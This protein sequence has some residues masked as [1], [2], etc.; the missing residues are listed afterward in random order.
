[1]QYPWHMVATT[2]AITSRSFINIAA[3]IITLDVSDNNVHLIEREAFSGINRTLEVLLL[4]HNHLIQILPHFFSNLRKLRVLDLSY[5][6]L[7]SLD[8]GLVGLKS[9]NWLNL[10]R[11]RI[12]SLPDYFILEDE[13][14]TS[15]IVTGLT[16]ELQ[17]SLQYN[18]LRYIPTCSIERLQFSNPQ[19]TIKIISL[20]NN[21]LYCDCMD[22]VW[23][24]AHLAEDINGTLANPTKCFFT[25]LLDV[26]NIPLRPYTDYTVCIAPYSDSGHGG[27]QEYYGKICVRYS[28]VSSIGPADKAVD[29]RL[30][31]EYV[32]GVLGFFILILV[33]GLVSTY[34]VKCR[35]GHITGEI[36][37]TA[38]RSRLKQ[39]LED[40]TLRRGTILSDRSTLPVRGR[41]PSGASKR[42]ASKRVFEQSLLVS[43]TTK[44][45]INTNPSKK[46]Y[47]IAASVREM[48][49]S[50]SHLDIENLAASSETFSNDLSL[51]GVSPIEI[52]VS[53]PSQASD[54]EVSRVTDR[55][56][57]K[58]SQANDEGHLSRSEDNMIYNLKS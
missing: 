21:A 3:D 37:S 54:A 35:P 1:M 29:E 55:E 23:A 44:I 16:G 5:N 41:A 33:C 45:V 56:T 32:Y 8:D 25:H 31:Q 51:T 14:C 20:A 43:S 50:T 24:E 17:I 15:C 7:V 10:D 30:F 18:S 28:A 27:H 42:D 40:S 22:A 39:E 46:R 34:F 2:S 6:Q 49:E 53:L 19:S 26:G 48:T 13:S 4:H 38:Y 12:Q 57:V 36:T 11:N 58:F 9:L 52:N 47:S